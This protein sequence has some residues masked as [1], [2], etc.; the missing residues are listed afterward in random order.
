MT[1]LRAN[2]QKHH[3]PA[4]TVTTG[5]MSTASAKMPAASMPID[6]QTVE[7]DHGQ[8]HLTRANERK[9]SRRRSSPGKIQGRMKRALIAMVWENMTDNQAAVEFDLHVTSIR[10]ALKTPQ[11]LAFVRGEREVLLTREL[12]RNSHALIDVRD[13]SGNGNAR[14]AAVRALEQLVEDE[15]RAPSHARTPGIVIMITDAVGALVGT[16]P[17]PS[18][19]TIEHAEKP[20]E[21]DDE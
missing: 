21:S 9:T 8:G 5:V 7:K 3:V 20:M 4:T 17:A 6:S 18:P 13:K 15:K 2:R 14:V 10:S 1:R 11:G 12:A 16:T 19:I